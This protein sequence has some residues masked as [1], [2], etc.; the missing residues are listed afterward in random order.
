MKRQKIAIVTGDAIAAILA[1][2]QKQIRT[3]SDVPMGAEFRGAYFDPQRQAFLI[4]LEHD[5]FEPVREGE[6]IPVLG[7]CFVAPITTEI[8][9]G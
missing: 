9:D 2:G 7:D 1:C 3:D 6:L 8:S 5:S 4:V